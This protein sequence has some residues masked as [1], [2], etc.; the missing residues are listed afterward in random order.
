M[1]VRSPMAVVVVSFNTRAVLERC[2]RSVIAAAPVETVVVDNGSTDG[3]LDLVRDSFPGCRLIVSDQNRGYGEAANQGIAAC[4]APMILLLNS[5]T[6][7]APEALCALGGY[8]A[9]RPQVALAGPRLVNCD[10]SLQR[11]T[12]SYPSAADVFLAESGLHLAL[13]H[14]PL[15][16]ERLH[17]T[18]SHTTARPVPWVLGAAL[19]IR[20]SAFEAV[21]GFDPAYFMY[22]EEVDL[23]RRLEGAGFETH[24]AP[25]TT[26]VHMGGA[27]TSMVPDAM[28]RELLISRKRYL[29]RHGSPR[30]AAR[31]LGVLQTAAVARLIRDAGLLLLVRD[32]ERRR[33]LRGSV[34]SWRSLLRNRELWQP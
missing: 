19:A 31:V 3:S 21:G 17:R 7:L 4:S 23:C 16:R 18:W 6:V 20:R 29:R 12:Y 2:L 27:S 28:R 11:S 1:T 24:F 34:S 13:R 5:D 30:S 10:G 33:Q 26:V 8:L 32:R 22:G 9:D 14:V 15:L 25:V